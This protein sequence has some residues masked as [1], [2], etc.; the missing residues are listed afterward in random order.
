MILLIKNIFASFFETFRKAG[1]INS[2]A[3]RKELI[4][5]YLI[6]FF[7][8]LIL[9]IPRYLDLF[10]I[11]G[12][13]NIIMLIISITL[14][15]RRLHDFNFSGWWYFLIN[16]IGFLT[17]LYFITKNISSVILLSYFLVGIQMIILVLKKG[18]KG[19]NRFGP[20][21]E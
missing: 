12:I 14:S 3:N 18:T 20:E 4:Y 9:V 17:V 2:R 19:S 8:D 1:K 5:F 10:I 7:I 6:W 15:I 16:L 11:T 21:P 13:I